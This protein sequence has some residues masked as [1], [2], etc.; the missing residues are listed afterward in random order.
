VQAL[1]RE[2]GRVHGAHE[3]KRAVEVRV[4]RDRADGRERRAG[5]RRARAGERL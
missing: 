2:A 5:E 4:P 1:V 3:G